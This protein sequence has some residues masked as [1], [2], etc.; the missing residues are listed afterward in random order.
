M[1]TYSDRVVKSVTL[2]EPGPLPEEAEDLGMY[3][4]TELKRL[5][6][7]LFNQATFRLERIH[8]EPER[9][10][11]GDVRYA[12]GTDWNPGSGE[13]FYYYKKGSPGSW[14]LLG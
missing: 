2:Y 10:R 5:G 11:E 12:D 1:A 6:N 3:M 8:E 9:P 14:V 13:G 7:T 4:V